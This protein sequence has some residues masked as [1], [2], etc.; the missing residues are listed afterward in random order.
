[1]G[2]FQSRRHLGERGARHI[3]RPSSRR[4]PFIDPKYDT[5]TKPHLKTDD[6][7]MRS[8]IRIANY[9]LLS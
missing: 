8:A 7:V 2:L 5:C 3:S 4:L 6:R 1:M 9:L